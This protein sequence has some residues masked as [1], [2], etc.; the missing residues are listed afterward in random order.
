MKTGIVPQPPPRRPRPHRTAA[1]L[2]VLAGL[3]AGTAVVVRL[4]GGSPWSHGVQGCVLLATLFALYGGGAW[5]VSSLRRAWATA[6]TIGGAAAMQLAALTAPPRYSD[7]LYRY[8]WD[9]RVQ[10]H[11]IDPYRYVPVSS[12]LAGLRTPD[13]FP[14][15]AGLGHC[16]SS[17]PD[18]TAGCTLLNRPLVH[19]IYPPVAQAYFW[20]V[21][22][23]G[24]R[25]VQ[26]FAAVAAVVVAAILVRGLPRLGA[27]ARQAVLWAWCPLVAIEAGNNGHVDVVA[28]A[29]T[30]AALLV[31]GNR[32]TLTASRAAVGGAVLGLAVATK[33]T[34]ALLVPAAVR[35]RPLPLLSSLSGVVVGVYLP[36]VAA[37]GGGVSGFLSGYLN[38]EGYDSGKRFAVLDLILP[39][40]WAAPSALVV[41]AATAV[42]VWWYADPARPWHGAVVMTGVALL[43]AAPS[44]AW[45]AELLVLLVA[46]SGR[47]ALPW[48]AVVFAGYAGQLGT[49]LGWTYGAA[50]L[51]VAGAWLV[52]RRTASSA[53]RAAVAVVPIVPDVADVADVASGQAAAE[54][55]AP[56]DV[57]LPCLD[58]AAAL[59]FVLGRM[60]ARYRAIVV[61]N[62]SCDGSPEV[63]ARLGAVVVHEPRRGFGAACHAGLLAATAD[64]VCFLDCDG[65]FD[66]ADLPK[67]TAPVLAGQADLFLGQRRPTS[68]S[69]WPPHARLANRLLTHRIR[70]TTGVALRDL[71][72]MR[73]ARRTALLDLEITDRRFGYPLEMVLK[74][75]D[76]GWHIGQTDVPYAP[77]TGKSK[78]TGTV[79]GTVKAVGDMR[80]VWK[81]ATG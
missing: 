13:L 6:L 22:W 29:L 11:G 39:T 78:V 8:V 5:L 42:L 66:P 43:V 59:P 25:G 81:A 28:M 12:H 23:S 54:G 26:V 63:A 68:R 24:P 7:D 48:L 61:D 10:A 50:A 21:H 40:S 56:I 30:A 20:A 73:A 2:A 1:A 47:T 62:G 70:R 38:E 80:K 16:V 41:L 45:Y 57:I 27:D 34:P 9:G 75:A 46:F 74:A 35:R 49:G 32:R 51:F 31:L 55:P 37:V 52:R 53:A 19:T 60:P 33:V 79:G 65:S 18:I 72:P 77:R 36:H 76:A 67:V 17:G 14:A 44:Y 4:P 3:V 69:A 58:E 71:G 64:V 15:T